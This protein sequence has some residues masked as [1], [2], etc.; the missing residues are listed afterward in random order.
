MSSS[1]NRITVLGAGVLGAQISFQIAYS[2]F[3]VTTYDISDAALKQAR[4]R[5]DGIAAAYPTEV[6][7]ATEAAVQETIERIKFTSE[8]PSAV[9]GADLVIEAVPENLKLK[10]DVFAR[11]AAFAPP[12]AVV[13]TNSST[14][15]PSDLMDSTGRPDRFLALHFANH[16]WVNNI[17]EVMGSPKT[18]PRVYERVVAFAKDI[19]MV[20]IELHKEQPGYIV[21]FLLGP[22]LMAAAGLL[23]RGVADPATIDTTWRIATGAP[24]GPFEIFDVIGLRTAYAVA[25]AGGRDRQAWAD[26]LK[27]NYIDQ[28]K[29]GV[30]SGEGFYTYTMS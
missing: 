26:Y 13:V 21:N 5:F 15:L 12:A 6:A 1:F 20:P 8:L 18:D 9:Q 10:R 22:L 3:E 28:G 27:T 25:N 23:L 30:E 19:G 11:I 7:G 29:L 2:G 16:I 24:K 17:A 4:Q 14:L